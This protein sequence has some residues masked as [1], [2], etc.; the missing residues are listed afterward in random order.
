M[1]V[2]IY[3]LKMKTLKKICTWLRNIIFII[4]FIFLGSII[5]YFINYEKILL[6]PSN[7]ISERLFG[8]TVPTESKESY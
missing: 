4:F 6:L 3:D 7:K 5:G 8:P 1:Q 2:N